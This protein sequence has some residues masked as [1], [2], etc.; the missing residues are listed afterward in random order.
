MKDSEIEKAAAYHVN[1]VYGDKRV[2]SCN[3]FDFDLV[4]QHLF[5]AG[6]RWA[7]IEQDDQTLMVR[8]PEFR[9]YIHNN[10]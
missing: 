9:F 2:Y 4:A 5:E 1:N 7:M 10:E 8:M 6:A 3:E